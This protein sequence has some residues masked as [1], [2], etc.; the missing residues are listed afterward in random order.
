MGIEDLGQKATE[1][2]GQAKGLLKSA[3]AEEISDTV[4][5]G[6]ANLANKVTGGK[7]ADQVE[8]VRE[9]LDDAIGSD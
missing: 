6:A 1:L 4:L 2:A 7:F 9:R 5:D 3:Q 8:D